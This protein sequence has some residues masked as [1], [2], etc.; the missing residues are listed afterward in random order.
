MKRIWRYVS[1]LIHPFPLSKT[2][3]QTPSNLNPP[4]R[5]E[6]YRQDGEALISIA[7]KET[8]LYEYAVAEIDAEVDSESHGQWSIKSRRFPQ[9]NDTLIPLGADPE[10]GLVR[11]ISISARCTSESI[12]LYLSGE[13][14]T[15]A[16]GWDNS[17]CGRP[18]RRNSALSKWVSCLAIGERQDD[19]L[20]LD[21]VYGRRRNPSTNSK[22]KLLWVCGSHRSRRKAV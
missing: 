6:I 1:D 9:V 17:S 3:I 5:A 21:R 19:W 8:Q 2:N 12:L 4:L 13:A 16:D 20:G 7:N 15:I 22:S 14:Y 18:E 11:T 10:E